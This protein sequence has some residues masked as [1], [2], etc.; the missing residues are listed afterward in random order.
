MTLGRRDDYDGI[1]LIPNV[2]PTIVFETMSAK[3]S[4]AQSIFDETRKYSG[5]TICVFGLNKRDQMPLNQINIPDVPPHFFRSFAFQWNSPAQGARENRYMMP[6]I[7]ARQLVMREANEIVNR[8]KAVSGLPEG[9]PAG[10]F[11]Y[12]WIDGDATDDQSEQIPKESLELLTGKRVSILSGTYKWRSSASI[13]KTHYLELVDKINRAEEN[14]RT[15]FYYAY[16]KLTNAFIDGSALPPFIGDRGKLSSYYLP[17]TSFMMS[18]DAHNIILNG[19][20]REDVNQEQ[21]KES[22]KMLSRAGI[23]SRS[24]AF[25]RSFSISKPLKGEFSADGENYLGAGLL[26]LLKE[27][28]QCS[29]DDFYDE[30]CKMRQSVFEKFTLPDGVTLPNGKTYEEHKEHLAEKIYRY[31]AAHYQQISRELSDV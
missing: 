12:R 22:M 1:S 10:K 3:V 8:A 31:Y 14:L 4:E 9:D 29:L 2:K 6:F 20:Y 30:L 17:E 27:N 24:V 7:E 19:D 21:S 15:V 16:G 13:S 23:S 18:E 11:I 28:E 26:R 5:N 25:E